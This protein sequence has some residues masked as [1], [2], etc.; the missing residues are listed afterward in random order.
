MKKENLE[1][2]RKGEALAKKYLQKKGYR[3][4]EQNHRTKYS[5][6]DLIA[7]HKGVLVFIEVRTKVG[8]QFGTPEESFNRKKINKLIWNAKAYITWKGYL[9]QCRIDAVCIVLDCNKTL[10]RINHYRNITWVKP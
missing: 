1:I 2:G 7:R 4:I 8:D 3:V 5:E 9:K 6:I 10:K